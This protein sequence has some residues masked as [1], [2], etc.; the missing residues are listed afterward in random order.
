MSDQPNPNA[1][2]L[3]AGLRL[4][5]ACGLCFTVLLVLVLSGVASITLLYSDET[6][7]LGGSGI[8]GVTLQVVTQL[9]PFIRHIHEWGGYVAIVLAGWAG[10]EVLQFGR[11]LKRSANE[12][13][14]KSGRWMPAAGVTAMLVLTLALLLQVG[15]GM[16]AAG[17]LHHEKDTIGAPAAWDRIQGMTDAREEME[18]GRGE[19]A[20]EWHTREF[21]YLI[22]FGALLLVAAAS[23]TRKIA[24]EAKRQNTPEKA[25]EPPP[26][27]NPDE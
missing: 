13:W 26:E 10:M 15:S 7:A 21:N 27:T 17:Y 2:L 4:Q 8:E 18:V 11:K 24:K 22:A 9:E 12:D 6:Y 1:H 5:L 23:T 20:V 19:R 25:P 16:R 3:S 14:S